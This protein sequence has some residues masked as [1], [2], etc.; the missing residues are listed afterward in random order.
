[1]T[2]FFFSMKFL[3]SYFPFVV[4]LVLESWEIYSVTDNHS[5]VFLFGKLYFGTEQKVVSK[6]S[7]I[8]VQ[9]E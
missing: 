8:K 4:I 7:R 3:Q 2:E 9:N 1:M 6:L 5:E